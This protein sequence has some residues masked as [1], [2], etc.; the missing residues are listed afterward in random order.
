MKKPLFIIILLL[1]AFTL[2]ICEDIVPF[3]DT[4]GIAV[5]NKTDYVPNM[6]KLFDSAENSI[7]AMIYQVRYYEKYP[8]GVN[9]QMYKALIRAAER[10][11]KV[12]IIVDQSSWNV[13]STLK[14]EQFAEYMKAN[15]VEVYFDPAD[16]TTHTK[17]VIVDSLYTV[18]GSTNWSFYAFE[19]NNES[20]VIVKSEKLALDYVDYFHRLLEFSTVELTIPR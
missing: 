19:K 8:D 5:I 16:K 1:G 15:G 13:S 14:N 17:V 4:E 11:V 9:R 6:I 12:Q 2:I 20:A 18:I 7:Q 3:Y 10:D